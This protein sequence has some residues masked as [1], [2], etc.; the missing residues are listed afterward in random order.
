MGN[1]RC[2]AISVKDACGGEPCLNDQGKEQSGEVHCDGESVW[3]N[4]VWSSDQIGDRVGK[5]G[6]KE[7]ET[8]WNNRGRDAAWKSSRGGDEATWWQKQEN[9]MWTELQQVK[10]HEEGRR[11]RD[12]SMRS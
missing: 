10:A 12:L 8:W 3:V 9:A 1:F 7:G 4:H 11:S 6:D 5:D 2:S